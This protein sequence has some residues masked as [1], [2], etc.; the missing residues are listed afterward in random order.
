MD[1]ETPPVLPITWQSLALA[2]WQQQVSSRSPLRDMPV[3]SQPG[4]DHRKLF[5]Y[6]VSF[7]ALCSSTTS[8]PAQ[9][10]GRW[11]RS[12]NLSLKREG[13]SELNLPFR[14]AELPAQRADSVN[15]KGQRTW[16]SGR[17]RG[18]LR[19]R[20]GPLLLDVTSKLPRYQVMF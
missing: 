6:R 19:K 7:L 12:S 13:N 16:A 8:L 17:V 11:P 14:A 9:D 18:G 3:F 5:C 4:P 15:A 2:H 1:L 20:K 10:S